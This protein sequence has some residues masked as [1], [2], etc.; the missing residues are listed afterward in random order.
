MKL[1]NR[2]NLGTKIALFVGAIL[3]VVCAAMA[4]VSIT[5]ETSET[6]AHALQT[7]HE[8]LRAFAILLA[9]SRP[10][11]VLDEPVDDRETALSWDQ[12]EVSTSAAI[13][14][15]AKRITG[16]DVSLYAYDPSDGTFRRVMTTFA[17]ASG[18]RA[19]G[20]T[21]DPGGQTHAELRAGRPYDQDVD[22][23]G[24][25][26]SGGYEPI[27]T[28]DGQVVGALFSGSS[29]DSLNAQVMS[30]VAYSVLTTLAL[31]LIGI[32]ATYLVLRRVLRPLEKMSEV[33]AAF[34]NRRFDVEVPEIQTRDEIGRVAQA[35]T[36]LRGQ[37][38]EAEKLSLDA[39]RVEEQREAQ[40]AIQTRVVRDLEHGLRRLA[41]GDLSEPI[42]SPA[43]DPFPADYESLRVS[44]NSALDRIGDAVANVMG[45]GRGVREASKEISQ[46]SRELSSRAES[47]AATLEESA[48]ALNELTA[49]I[50]STADRA[51]EARRASSENHGCRDRGTDRSAGR[52]RDEG[53]REEFRADHAH[54]LRD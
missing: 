46:A 12:G 23:F 50:G 6:R 41:D 8:G 14:D 2:L 16:A 24:S 37:L 31:L 51:A 4:T 25:R 32:G 18:T 29:I 3:I 34:A 17:D 30:D 47:Q 10:G 9:G 48:A 1:L 26:F 35:L 54:H 49:S 39:A 19:I 36:I 40:M 45:I 27:R 22:V 52:R 7:M 28:P 5:R 20:T 38:V 11:L 13:V 33:I 21:L 43:A 42:D 53:H 44:Y 15:Q